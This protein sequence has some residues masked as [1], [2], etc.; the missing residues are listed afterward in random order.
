[1]KKSIIILIL[2]CL[3]YSVFP[4]KSSNTA[5]KFDV[6]DFNKK[7]ETAA[8]LVEYDFA[9]WKSTDEVMK[10][11]KKELERLGKEWFCF[12][13]KNRNWHAVYGKLVND[14]YDLVF[15]LTVDKTGKASVIKEKVDEKF[16]ILHSKALETA[17]NQ[18]QIALKGK[19]A[20][21]FN[22]YIKQ[23][24]DKSFSVWLLP[25]FQTNGV[26]VYGAEFVY[27]ID[28]NA[29]KILKDESYMQENFRGFQTG[30][31]REIWLNYS[32]TEKPTLGAIFFVWYY[33]S[34]FTNIFIETKI[35]TSTVVKDKSTETYL[36][37]HVEKEKSA[38]K[39]DK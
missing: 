14:K 22:Q 16:L 33:K 6:A 18:M 36:W 17:Q 29:T 24:D 26:A 34:Y 8:W 37:V 39:K 5:P 21:K 3:A 7:F 35:N 2:L 23:N 4:Q 12:Q 27:T 19:D 1:M 9:A 25:A 38:D 10:Q 28:Q 31:P 32:E 11:D 20:P 30:N 15:H 13:D